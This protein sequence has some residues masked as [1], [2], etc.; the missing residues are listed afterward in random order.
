MLVRF[1]RTVNSVSVNV[2]QRRGDSGQS[3]QLDQHNKAFQQTPNSNISMCRNPAFYVFVWP[4]RA[5]HSLG[6]AQLKAIVKPHCAAQSR[7]IWG[8]G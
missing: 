8:S 4:L 2:R 1:D 6:T 5:R 7:A 3:S